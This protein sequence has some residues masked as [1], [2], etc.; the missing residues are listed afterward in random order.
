MRDERRQRF[1]PY[2]RALADRMGLKDWEATVSDQPPRSPTAMAG[3]FLHYGQRRAD[4]HLGDSFL[5]EPTDLQRLH[6]AHELVHLHF[7]AADGV[8]EDWLD[9]SQYAGFLRLFEYG[10][11]AVATAWA[12]HLPLPPG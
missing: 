3:V 10:V 12:P 2:V 9:T 6:L 11:D 7:A 8:A 4:I 1:L 5:D